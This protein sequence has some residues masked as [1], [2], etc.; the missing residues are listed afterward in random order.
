MAH[1]CG[2][3]AWKTGEGNPSKQLG[4]EE[5]AGVVWCGVVWCVGNGGASVQR[6]RGVG[7]WECRKV[8]KGEVAGREGGGDGEATERNES[9]IFA[10]THKGE[11]PKHGV[12]W[13][14]STGRRGEGCREPAGQTKGRAFL[15][16]CRSGRACFTRHG[17]EV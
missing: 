2:G 15:G 10:L 17:A 11:I 8:G 9:V 14:D 7:R 1:C 3:T 5:M 4:G 12:G 13:L 16:R 6:G